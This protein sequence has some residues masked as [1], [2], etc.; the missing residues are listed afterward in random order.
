M[1]DHFE[2]FAHGEFFFGGMFMDAFLKPKPMKQMA[3]S[4]TL[5]TK[6]KGDGR[7]RPPPFRSTANIAQRILPP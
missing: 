2:W 6:Q 3:D 7:F 1:R 4:Q 5:Q